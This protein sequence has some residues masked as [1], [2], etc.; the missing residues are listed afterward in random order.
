MITKLYS[1]KN[2]ITIDDLQK[3][4]YFYDH[5]NEFECN[6]DYEKKWNTNTFI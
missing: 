5:C 1:C 6:H 3:E 2:K 4:K